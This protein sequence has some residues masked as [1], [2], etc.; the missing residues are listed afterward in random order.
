MFILRH[1]W[2]R[3][4]WYRMS[5]MFTMLLLKMLWT[6]KTMI[7]IL[8]KKK[9]NPWIL[10]PV[11]ILVLALHNSIGE[12][13]M[14]QWI[15]CID[16]FKIWDYMTMNTVYFMH[17]DINWARTC[18]GVAAITKKCPPFYLIILLKYFLYTAQSSTMLYSGA[19]GLYSCHIYI[20]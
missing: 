9:V 5:Q 16:S 15:I 12:A 10:I 14:M 4:P 13:I 8:I 6:N 17:L 7:K 19:I 3:G 11:I 1:I 20:F 18:L 2:N